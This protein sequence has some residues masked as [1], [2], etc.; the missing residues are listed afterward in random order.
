MQRLN[1]QFFE[2]FSF[3]KLK[4]LANS[5]FL[6]IRIYNLNWTFY[7]NSYICRASVCDYVCSPLP[8]TKFSLKLQT[9]CVK[10]KTMRV[11][12]SGIMAEGQNVKQ[13]PPIPEITL[14]CNNRGHIISHQH[15]LQPL[16]DLD[17]DLPLSHIRMYG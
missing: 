14:I 3:C 11:Q 10:Q 2:K 16:L 9:F 6:F 15:F 1:E 12:S 17:C 4:Y 8:P 5:I 13:I 7:M